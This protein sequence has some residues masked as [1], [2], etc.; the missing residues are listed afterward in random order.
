MTPIAHRCRIE[1][2]CEIYGPIPHEN[3]LYRQSESSLLL[4]LGG[5]NKK[6]DG[7]IPGK[8]FEYIGTGLPI[9]CVGPPFGALAKI[10]NDNR[11][12]FFSNDPEQIANYLSDQLSEWCK[13]HSSFRKIEHPDHVNQFSYRIAANQLA[14]IFTAISL[15]Q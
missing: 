14:G 2:F 4:V 10:I 11:L 3:C 8:L 6:E 1:K 13:S 15:N 12:G 5:N 7:W 9:L